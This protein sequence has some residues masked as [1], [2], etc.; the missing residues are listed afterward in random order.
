MDDT[1][2]SII[3]SL[4]VLLRDNFFRVVKKHL[5]LESFFEFSFKTTLHNT[6][7]GQAGLHFV[8][9]FAFI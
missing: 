3:Y 2:Y 7:G 4:Q 6:V 9:V 5:Y 8:G 1:C